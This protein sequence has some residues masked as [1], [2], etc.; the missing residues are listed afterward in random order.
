MAADQIDQ[1]D[2]VFSNLRIFGPVFAGKRDLR[3]RLIIL[4]QAKSQES[5]R[6]LVRDGDLHCGGSGFSG[7]D[8]LILHNLFLQLLEI[9]T[10][11]D[12]VDLFGKIPVG[13]DFFRR[14]DRRQ[15]S[16]Q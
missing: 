3:P 15:Q 16:G 1:H 6:I 13:Q 10:H 7:G 14:Q 9:P 12:A 2:A 4:P 8:H 11:G 5:L